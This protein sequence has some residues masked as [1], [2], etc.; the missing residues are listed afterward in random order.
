MRRVIK[1]R[2]KYSLIAKPHINQH[3]GPTLQREF[4]PWPELNRAIFC[5]ILRCPMN[6]YLSPR[7]C[8]GSGDCRKSSCR[9]V[10]LLLASRVWTV[11]NLKR[12]CFSWYVI[13]GEIWTR[14][15][16]FQWTADAFHSWTQ[17]EKQLLCDSGM[18]QRWSTRFGQKTPPHILIFLDDAYIFTIRVSKSCEDP[19]K[20]FKTICSAHGVFCSPSGKNMF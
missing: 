5:F 2:N 19:E 13:V 14:A 11:C 10:N 17:K 12:R 7:T 16:S 8:C 4:V 3:N 20:W 18:S 15:S 9:H 1:T 6:A